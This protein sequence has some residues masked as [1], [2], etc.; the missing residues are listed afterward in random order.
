MGR[1]RT[2]EHIAKT[3]PAIDNERLKALK[4]ILPEAFTEEHLDLEKL[5]AVLGTHTASGPER[6]SFSWAGKRDAITALQTPSDATLTPDKKHSIKYDTTR[7]VFIE[8]DNLEVLK[9][10]Y[11]PYFGRVKMIYID[12]P[13]NTGNDFVYPDD[14]K[15]PID[16]YLRLTGQKK[17]DGSLSTSN[18]ETSGRYHSAWLS[19]M[20]PRLF[21][22]RQLLT[23]DG[24]IFVSIDDHEVHHLRLLLNEIFGEENV[25][26]QFVWRKT[27]GGKSQGQ[28]STQH[29]YVLCFARSFDKLRMTQLPLSDELRL[30]YEFEDARG[31]YD[32][33]ELAQGKGL[34]YGPTLS[35]EIE[36][37]DGSRIPAPPLDK[38]YRWRKQKWEWGT[39]NDYVVVKRVKGRWVPFTKQYLDYDNEGNRIERGE[40]PSAW[41]D[42]CGYS[43][44]GTKNFEDLMGEEGLFSYPKPVK[45][46]KHLTRIATTGHD[47]VLDFFAGSCTTAQAVLELNREDGG[48]R[49]FI[50]VQL[51]EPLEE[52]KKL[53]DGT[54]LN[55]IADIGRERIARVI[56]RMKEERQTK[57]GKDQVEDL[58]FRAFRLTASNYKPFDD[59]PQTTVERFAER[60]AEVID[61]LR[62]GWKPEP[63][64]YEV[65]LKEGF[66]LSLTVE[67]VD[68][69]PEVYRVAD[70][71]KQQTFVVCLDDKV[72]L[73]SL[74]SLGLKKG[75]LFI[76]RDTALDDTSAANLALQCRLKTI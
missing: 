19:M 46:I 43:R 20:Y 68:A 73:S 71:D 64:I 25:V 66:G 36:A 7:N 49:R 13:Y 52:P 41:L 37:P 26:A 30:K 14:Y 27:V 62:P 4:E 39:Q 51:P 32:I 16:T 10:L 15:H 12:P 1:T 24:V 23:E 35:Y 18:P 11:K 6:Y 34:S 70:P 17:E 42:D 45:L 22:A 60:L 8:G 47:I 67:R 74:K 38:A 69:K 55:T 59:S 40:A 29:E 75:D 56:A 31:K 44:T 58:G 61:P 28:V 9:L 48:N 21:L 50:M 63:V 5:Q 76:C 57:L 3:T 72:T 2:T 33:R 65:A 53:K 54:A